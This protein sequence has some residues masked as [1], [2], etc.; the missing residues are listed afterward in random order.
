MRVEP[1]IALLN[2][3]LPV[4]PTTVK[5]KAPLTV[6]ETVMLPEP[7]LF[8]NV[9]APLKVI[10]LRNEMAAPVVFTVPDKVTAPPPVCEKA[11]A[12]EV[13]APATNV[14]PPDSAILTGPAAVVMRL[15]LIEKMVPVRE[16]P[17]TREVVRFWKVDVPAPAVC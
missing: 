4:P 7:P 2:T 12:I 11:P 9:V 1:P 10:L 14:R 15:P 6:P 16:M 3:T 5:S 13:L 8:V 17:P